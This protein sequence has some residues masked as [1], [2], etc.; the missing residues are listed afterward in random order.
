[1][2]YYH[3]EFLSLLIELDG[4]YFCHGVEVTVVVQQEKIMF[5]SSLNDKAVDRASDCNPLLSTIHVDFGRPC[6]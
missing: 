3:E 5:K 6:K 2:L 1:M 4:H